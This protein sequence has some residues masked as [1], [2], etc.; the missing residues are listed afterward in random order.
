ME[1]L[2]QAVFHDDGRM[3]VVCPFC[4]HIHQHG[5]AG[6]VD[7]SGN[8]RTAHCGLGEYRVKGM[9]DIRLAAQLLNR[10][11]LDIRRKREA[12]AAQAAQAARAHKKDVQSS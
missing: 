5:D 10:R 7:V 2:A 3:Y 8:V 6:M 9:F 12:R 1:S 4:Y 11:E